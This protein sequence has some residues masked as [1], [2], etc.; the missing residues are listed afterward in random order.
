[1]LLRA[2][3]PLR[4]Y[5][6]TAPEVQCST[7]MD[8]NPASP[9]HYFPYLKK[10]FDIRGFDIRL[11]GR[12]ASVELNGSPLCIQHA[13]EVVL[14]MLLSGELV[15]KDGTSPLPADQPVEYADIGESGERQ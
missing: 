15:F 9:D 10:K 8:R 7:R 5:R 14:S 2:L 3:K 11:C 13:G 1:M 6:P 4:G 12:S